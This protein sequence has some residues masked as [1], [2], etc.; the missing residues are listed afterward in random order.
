[1]KAVG[2]QHSVGQGLAYGLCVGRRQVDGHVGDLGPPGRWLLVQPRY[3]RVAGAALDLSEQTTGAG[4]VNKP[5]V[6]PIAHQHPP[7]CVQVLSEHWAAA[8]GLVDPQN[9][10]RWQWRRQRDPDVLN[11][12]VVHD[13]PV[14]TEVGCGLGDNPTLFGDRIPELGP[15]PRRQPRAGPHCGQRLGERG[16]RAES[17]LAAPSTLMPDQP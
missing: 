7:P 17:F 9:L 3:G 12:R 14:H 10:H 15:Q 6:P 4:G 1:M 11:E 8:A 2:H 5:G 13:G 16:P